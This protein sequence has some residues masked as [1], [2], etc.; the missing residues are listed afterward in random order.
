MLHG[1][2]LLQGLPFQPVE[3]T[4]WSTCSTTALFLMARLYKPAAFAHRLVYILQSEDVTRG[5]LSDATEKPFKLLKKTLKCEASFKSINKSSEGLF[6][7]IFILY[8]RTLKGLIFAF[9]FISP[10]STCVIYVV[11][12]RIRRRKPGGSNHYPDWQWN[13]PYYFPMDWQS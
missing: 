4:A 11:L 5:S 9:Y 2:Y 6:T 10:G 3:N 13:T 7:R 12:L 1:C 8:R